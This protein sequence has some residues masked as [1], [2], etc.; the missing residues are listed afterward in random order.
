MMQA[1]SKDKCK[2]TERSNLL[3][4]IYFVVASIGA[5]SYLIY[6]VGDMWDTYSLLAIIMMV[7][8]IGPSYMF[9]IYMRN[10]RHRRMLDIDEREAQTENSVSSRQDQ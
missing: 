1:D 4:V 10:I 2:R 7:A 5:G 6:K 3:F 8:S 9:I